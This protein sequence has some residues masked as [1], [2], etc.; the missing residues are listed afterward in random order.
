VVRRWRGDPRPADRARCV[1]ADAT[2]EGR[3]MRLLPRSRRGTWLLAGAVGVLRQQR[4]VRRDSPDPRELPWQP[5]IALAT[6]QE[7]NTFPI[8][9]TG[10]GCQP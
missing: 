2:T 4:A 1:A 8:H 3:V 7:C 6:L 9:I 10:P 5:G